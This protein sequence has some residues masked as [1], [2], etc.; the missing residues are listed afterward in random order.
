MADAFRKAI[1]AGREAYLSGLGRV[2]E[3]GA[4]PFI[5]PYRISSGLG[6]RDHE[7]GK[8]RKRKYHK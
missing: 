6:G 8:S 7:S 1:E 5:T 4:E 3:K 2:M